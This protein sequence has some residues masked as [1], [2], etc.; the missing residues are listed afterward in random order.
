MSSTTTAL[1]FLGG[2]H[3]RLISPATSIY[4]ISTSDDFTIEW[5]QK[6]TANTPFP[7]IFEGIDVTNNLSFA[8]GFEYTFQG[9][10]AT[11]P[12]FKIKLNLITTIPDTTDVQQSQIILDTVYLEDIKAKWIHFAICRKNGELR[13]FMNGSQIGNTILNENSFTVKYPP[14]FTGS[15]SSIYIGVNKNFNNTNAFGGLL[16]NF[17]WIV[18]SALY[19]S[20]FTPSNNISRSPLPSGTKFILSNMTDITTYIF[21]NNGGL[22]TYE[23]VTLS[24]I[25]TTQEPTITFSSITSKTYGDSS[26]SIT[27]LISSNS[28]GIYTYTSSNETVATIS[29][30]GTITILKAGSTTITVNQAANGNYTAGSASQTLTVNQATPVIT[31][32]LPILSYGDSSINLGD[33]VTST[34]GTNITYSSSDSNIASISGSMLTIVSAGIF[35]ITASQIAN[36]NFTSKSQ[37]SS[38]ITI[39]Q[40]TPVITF[41]T[42]PTLTYDPSTTTILNL[43]D[44]VTSTSGTAF[45]Y[46]S[47]DSSIASISGSILTIVSAGTFTITASQVV[48]TNFTSKSQTS[49]NITINQAIPV[50]TINTLPTLTYDPST[51]TT[52]NLGNYV[53]ST[54]N[55][56]LTYTSSNSN[57]SSI[58]GSTLTLVSA[59]TFTITA[60]QVANT[61]FTSKSQTSSNIIVRAI[62]NIT[63]NLPAS[64]IYGSLNIDLS[65]LVSTNSPGN[66]T[67]NSNNS[68]IAEVINSNELKLKGVGSVTITMNQS[69]TTNYSSNTLPKQLIIRQASESDP[70]I[71][72]DGNHLVRAVDILNIPFINVDT[73]NDKLIRNNELETNRLFTNTNTVKIVSKNNGA[74]IMY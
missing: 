73:Y 53:T 54:S 15:G 72:V 58:S 59:G 40:A 64:I 18:G 6:F 68:N 5:W 49:S 71:I 9:S 26:F 39:N 42:L 12:D 52:L 34:S 30:T 24:D 45:T 67:Y 11:S 46:T 57:V 56:T 36:T 27:S 10:P 7:T 22:V 16:Y 23:D 33:Y 69:S 13:V 55:A 14:P 17:I 29:A 1:K 48:N 3:S 41:N 44:Y 51:T 4:N 65:S 50:I 37:T 62:P 38:N 2:S 25:A 19:D 32:D 31:F 63:F 35:T 47:S 61:N 66:I 20:S 8:F 21:S 70:L 28:A 74:K 60:S 43:G